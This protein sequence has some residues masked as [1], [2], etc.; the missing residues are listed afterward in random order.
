MDP[1]IIYPL[2]LI[3][4]SIDPSKQ[5]ERETPSYNYRITHGSEVNRSP[6]RPPPTARLP[7]FHRPSTHHST[8]PPIY[9]S[10]H[11]AAAAT[12]RPILPSTH[13]SIHSPIPSP[14]QSPIHSFTHS[15]IHPP[16]FT[17]IHPQIA[18][19][20]IYPPS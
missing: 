8:Y 2:P 7:S 13:P 17:P 9:P 10:F 6:I 1:S 3:D 5:H 18:R 15:S 4:S 19:S 14:I 20:F 11:R 12:R 16:I